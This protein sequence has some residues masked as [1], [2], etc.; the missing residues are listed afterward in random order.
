[1]FH[2]LRLFLFL[3]FIISLPPRF[4]LFPYT[5][6]FRS[7]LDE[8]F[9]CDILD[10]CRVPDEPGQQPRQLSLIFRHQQLEGMLVASLG[11]LDQLLVEIPLIHPPPSLTKRCRASV[12][13]CPQAAAS[14]PQCVR[15][16]RDILEQKRD[17][18]SS[19]T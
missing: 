9:L 8:R 11:L 5:T 2:S 6:L 14:I 16:P 18:A 19:G 4:T 12:L 17:T 15:S 7:G 13:R 3:F 10:L 1:S